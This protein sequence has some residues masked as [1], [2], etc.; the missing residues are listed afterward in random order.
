MSVGLQQLS[1]GST[2]S[3]LIDL[4]NQSAPYLQD[5]PL[6]IQ[7]TSALCDVPDVPVF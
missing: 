4:F 7:D 3:V 1:S 2:D 6:L 5:A